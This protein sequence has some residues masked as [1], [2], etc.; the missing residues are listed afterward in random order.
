MA[1]MSQTVKDILQVV[2]FL[3]VVGILLTAF[4]IYPL[5]RS[6]AILGRA[7]V[8]NF[9]P[10][11]LGVNDPALLIEAGFAVDTFRVETD[12]LTTVACAFLTPA[13]DSSFEPQGTAILLH[14]ERAD[15]NSMIPLASAL[16]ERGF[17]VIVYDQRASGLSTGTYHSNGQYEA[18]DLQEL[19][20][21]LVF[22][23]KITHPLV[24]V[25]RSAGADAV[26]MATREEERLDAIVAIE[27]YL[28]TER[29]M[30]MIMEEHDM[31]WIPFPHTIFEFWFQLRSDYAVV[32]T[33]VDDIQEITKR[34]LVLAS[35]ESLQSPECSKLVEL[36]DPGL[37][38]TASLSG[39]DW[40]GTVVDFLMTPG[41][42][43]AEQ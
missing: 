34:T 32:Y 21:H 39:D 43:T 10:D 11:S 20:R 4:L 30:N 13:A 2:V 36:S 12:G 1:R 33:T 16:V 38:Q 15:R 26:L 28:S 24:A 14:D 3:L 19:I 9:D 23:D 18:T 40:I 37:L 42:E 8:D 22:R 5:N 27:P 6:K 41:E 29:W 31:F 17:M 35:T 25:G 7:D